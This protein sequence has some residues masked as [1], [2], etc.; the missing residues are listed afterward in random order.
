[1]DSAAY[2]SGGRRL[3]LGWVRGRFA[4]RFVLP[5]SGPVVTS[6]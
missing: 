2:G 1:M 4:R 5:F 3:V 6:G